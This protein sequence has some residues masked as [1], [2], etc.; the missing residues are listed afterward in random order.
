MPDSCPKPYRPSLWLHVA[1]LAAALLLANCD[2]THTLQV[3]SAAQT[4]CSPQ[5]IEITDDEAGFNSHSWVAWCNSDSYQC[6]GAGNNASCKLM[7]PKGPRSVASE[8][9]EAASAPAKR[10]A[11]AWTDHELAACGVMAHFL[12]TPNDEQ[13]DVRT[14]GGSVKMTLASSEL[15]GGK[16][17]LVVSC[18]PAQTK[19]ITAVSALDGARDGMLK[20][21]GATL[22]NERDIIGG[23]E[24]LFELNGEQG[25]ARLL[26]VNDRVVL[27]TAIPLSLI[28]AASAKRF[29]NSV[30]LSEEH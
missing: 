6:F 8:A 12:G 4:G 27:A 3:I 24:V 18:G 16:A 30:Q 10:P 26:W 20:N 1:A 22:S 17:A 25:L 2:V 11:L 29:V 19:K 7:A 13:R 23:R 5:D 14:K 9:S 21:I 15:G 28:G